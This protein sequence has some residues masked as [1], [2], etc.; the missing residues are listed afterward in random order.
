MDLVVMQME[1]MDLP[2]GGYRST[3]PLQQ[4]AL[5]VRT[6]RDVYGK[7]PARAQPRLELKK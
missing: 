6:I 3:N 7:R 4:V 2:G 5:H 1:A